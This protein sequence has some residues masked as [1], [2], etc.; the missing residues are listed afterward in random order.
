MT[1]EGPAEGAVIIW[2]EPTSW[3]G[4]RSNQKNN[5][6]EPIRIVCY[7]EGCL[8]RRNMLG[9][10]QRDGRSFEIV[11]SSPSISGIE[12]AVSTDFGVTALANRLAPKKLKRIEEAKNL[13]KLSDVIVGI[14]LNNKIDSTAARSIAA[15]LADLF[16]EGGS[17]LKAVHDHE[18][19]KIGA[20]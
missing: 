6:S 12:A 8:Y 16:V 3:H 4:A 9:A 10:L 2:R 1:S 20:A 5:A 19:F 18:G 11:Y 7:P 17:P 14:Y 13:P 15:R